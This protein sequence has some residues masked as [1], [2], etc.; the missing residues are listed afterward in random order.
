MRYVTCMRSPRKA[1]PQISKRSTHERM[2]SVMLSA[3]VNIGPVLAYQPDL[4]WDGHGLCWPG[5]S[6][7][8]R[9]GA[10][11]GQRGQGAARTARA[12]SQPPPSRCTHAC[13]PSSSAHARSHSCKSCSPSRPCARGMLWAPLVPLEACCPAGGVLSHL[14]GAPV[15][16]ACARRCRPGSARGPTMKPLRRGIYNSSFEHCLLRLAQRARPQLGARLRLSRQP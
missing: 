1:F 11:G 13:R 16:E 12:G 6:L 7:L 9:R 4:M 10:S 5:L 2:W 15:A 14:Q 8:I 3:P